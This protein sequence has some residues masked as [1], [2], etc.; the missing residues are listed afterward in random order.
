MAA[1]FA[2]ALLAPHLSTKFGV[3]GSVALWIIAFVCK[4]GECAL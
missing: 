1:V 4:V 3:C 2:V